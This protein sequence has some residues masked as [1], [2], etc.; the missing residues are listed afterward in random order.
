MKGGAGA[1]GQHFYNTS[2]ITSKSL[3]RPKR[4]VGTIPPPDWRTREVTKQIGRDA[5]EV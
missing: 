1:G 3:P 2:K 5:D 4:G